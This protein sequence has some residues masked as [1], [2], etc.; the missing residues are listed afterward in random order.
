ME[1][2]GTY[3]ITSY[4][5]N[6]DK[7]GEVNHTVVPTELAY[8]FCNQD[9]FRINRTKYEGRNFPF[10]ASNQPKGAEWMSEEQE[11]ITN[12][13]GWTTVGIIIFTI[14]VYLQGLVEALVSGLWGESIVSHFSSLLSQLWQLLICTYFYSFLFAGMF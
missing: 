14:I 11:V 6:G 2:I 12:V 13:Y 5:P 1:Y 4:D 9:M 7:Q 3:N 8:T 10:T